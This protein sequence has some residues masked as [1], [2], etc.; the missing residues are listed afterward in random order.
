VYSN[1]TTCVGD[2]SEVG[3][4]PD[5]ASPYGVLDMAGNVREW[6]NDWYSREYY[7]ISPYTNPPGPS[8][9]DMKVLRGGD[10][11]SGWY[12]LRVTYRNTR[13]IPEATKNW[14]GYRCAAPGGN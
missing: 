6:V 3:S 5:G 10:W 9:G 13:G 11:S 4:Y 12:D 1:E 2:T 14:I 7:S 8:S